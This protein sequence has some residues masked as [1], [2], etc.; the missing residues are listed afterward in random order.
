MHVFMHALL[1]ASIKQH[2]WCDHAM[3][4]VYDSAYKIGN[5]TCSFCYLPLPTQSKIFPVA[6]HKLGIV[7]QHAQLV[8]A[9][10]RSAATQRYCD[11]GLTHTV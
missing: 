2:A 4:T 7:V 6:V 3:H 10:C 8:T 9:H 1:H 5:A 11:V